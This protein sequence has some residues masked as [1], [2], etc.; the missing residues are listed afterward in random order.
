MDAGN[1]APTKLPRYRNSKGKVYCTLKVVHM[2]GFFLGSWHKP[3]LSISS[4]HKKAPLFGQ[5]PIPTLLLLALALPT[6]LSSCSSFYYYDDYHN[7]YSSSCY[8]YYYHYYCYYYYHY[9]YY[10][11]DCYLLLHMSYSLN[12]LKG[13]YMGDDIGDYYRA[14]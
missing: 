4:I 2:A 9:Y 10:Y 11:S 5:P 12:S 14:Y 7:A 13:G 1:R 3:V 8:Y 6:Y